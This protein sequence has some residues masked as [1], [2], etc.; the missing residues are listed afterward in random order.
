MSAAVEVP[1]RSRG[2]GL[3]VAL[4]LSLTLNV[5]VLGGLGWSMMNRPAPPPGGA[6][7]FIEIGRS[8]D[9][10]GDQRDALR[11]FGLHAREL[12]RTLREANGPIVREIWTEMGKAQPDAA[13]IQSLSDQVLAKRREFQHQMSQNLLAFLAV[14]SPEQRQRFVER[15]MSQ[16]GRR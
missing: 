3:W 11:Q 5:F 7:R 15:A 14:L 2:W 1:S 16:P 12:N 9:L 10:A 13:K 4:A 6:Q 8:L